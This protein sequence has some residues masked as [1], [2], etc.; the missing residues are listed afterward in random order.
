MIPQEL[1]SLVLSYIPYDPLYKGINKDTSIIVK[2]IAKTLVTD[3]S[4]EYLV[5]N[6][7]WNH[8]LYC[9]IHN[10]IEYKYDHI[11]SSLHLLHINK[12]FEEASILYRYFHNNEKFDY[13]N[14]QQ[15]LF[16]SSY[17]NDG[18]YS[19]AEIISNIDTYDITGYLTYGL[20]K[21]VNKLTQSLD[22]WLDFISINKQLDPDNF[23]WCSDWTKYAELRSLYSEPDKRLV[24]SGSWYKKWFEKDFTLT[25][26]EAECLDKNT[27]FTCV[28]SN[29]TIDTLYKNNAEIVQDFNLYN[30]RVK[31]LNSK[32]T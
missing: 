29:S 4:I 21:D 22:S 18:K 26:E 15:R 9:C 11:R 16:Y 28:L 1:W 13:L 3:E 32:N 5:A 17:L 19:L 14:N 10:D 2:N 31:Y 30:E 23:S 12:R 24:S 25:T 20:A 6:E 7:K 27:V 8:V